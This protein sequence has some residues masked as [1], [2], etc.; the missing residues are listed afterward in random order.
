MAGLETLPVTLEFDGRAPVQA[1][2]RALTPT[3][4]EYFL[5]EDAEVPLVGEEA[6]FEVRIAG[7]GASGRARV[8]AVSEIEDGLHREFVVELDVVVLEGAAA[9]AIARAGFRERV[10]AFAL[11]S[12]EGARILAASGDPVLRRPRLPDTTPLTP[13]TAQWVEAVAARTAPDGSPIYQG[14]REAAPP[15]EPGRVRP[16]PSR[17]HWEI[18]QR[19]RVR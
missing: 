8:T 15:P 18:E 2:T 9:K 11:R 10:E 12:R 17:H 3:R 13:R 16:K 14:M 19:F 6:S 1:I 4:L 7:S 5:A